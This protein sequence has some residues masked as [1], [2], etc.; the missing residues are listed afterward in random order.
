MSQC[1]RAGGEE[2]RGVG[3]HRAAPLDLLLVQCPR[4]CRRRVVA[5]LPESPS[6]IHG[7][8]TRRREARRGGIDVLVALSG[9]RQGVRGGDADC[10]GAANRESTDCLDDLRDRAA[11]ELD[12]L[13]GQAALVEEDDFRAIL[14]EPHDA[15]GV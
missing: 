8:R 12:L 3:R 9:E 5:H 6:E 10:R 4:T 1:S 2:V 11:L 7:R 15:F 14:L 13:F